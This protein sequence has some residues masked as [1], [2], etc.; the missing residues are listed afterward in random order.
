MGSIINKPVDF[1]GISR[2]EARGLNQRWRDWNESSEQFLAQSENQTGR[3]HLG[4]GNEITY[5]TNTISAPQDKSDGSAITSELR[6]QQ[7]MLI[8]MNKVQHLGE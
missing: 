6:T 2:K 8:T 3:E 7:H 1:Q 5:V 4:K